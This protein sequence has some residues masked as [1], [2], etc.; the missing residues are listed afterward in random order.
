VKIWLLL[1]AA[2]AACK[3][4]SDREIVNKL[5]NSSQVVKPAPVAEGALAKRGS[6]HREAF[7]S[8]GVIPRACTAEEAKK[9][10]SAQI[11]GDKVHIEVSPLKD[12]GW[13]GADK[14]QVDIKAAE[15]DAALIDKVSEGVL[16]AVFDAPKRTGEFAASVLAVT[17]ECKGWVLSINNGTLYDVEHAKTGLPLGDPDARKLITLQAGQSENQLAYITSLGMHAVGLPDLELRGIPTTELK[18]AATLMNAA[19]QTL[20]VQGDVTRDGALDVD[21]SKLKGD[22]HFDALTKDG[23]TGKVTWKLQWI[24]TDEAGNKLDDP[25]LELIPPGNE[26]GGAVGLMAAIDTYFGKHEDKA[27]NLDEMRDDLTAA[28]VKA[29]AALDKLVPRF[30]K[31]IPGG[32]QLSVKAPFDTDRGGIEWM[33]VDVFKISKS[34][35]EGTLNN[36]PNEV[37]ALKAGAHVKVKLGKIADFIYRKDGEKTVGGFSLEVMRAHGMDVPP[38]D[39]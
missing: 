5:T 39:D 13:D 21:A 23:G 3:G 10:L 36:D 27:V 4:S 33:W 25:D 6:L 29:R 19:A 8:W 38:L 32:E 2:L 24:N 11:E 15:G 7:A 14:T 35:I 1:V 16:V 12:L 18:N 20:I 9:K 30:A 26:Q 37:A 28:G 31:G 17:T 34:T 22:W